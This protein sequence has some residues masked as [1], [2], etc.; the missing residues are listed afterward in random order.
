MQQE[1]N[2][3]EAPPLLFGPDFAKKAKVDQVKAMR[4]TLPKK[5]AKDNFFRTA[6]PPR[7][8][9]GGGVNSYRPPSYSRGRGGG[10][11]QNQSPPEGLQSPHSS[12]TAEE[13]EHQTVNS[14]I[15]RMIVTLH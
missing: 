11:H 1:E 12:G 2:F 9:R 14:Q 8:G 3:K 4:A 13:L 6:P 7:Y 5:G 15:N 10:S